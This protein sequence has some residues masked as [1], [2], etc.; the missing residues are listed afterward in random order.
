[1]KWKSSRTVAENARLLLPK[2]ADKYFKAGRKAAGEEAPSAKDLHRFRIAT[3]RFRYS[4]EL[5]R[6]VYGDTLE[7]HIRSLRELQNVLGALSDYHSLERLFQGDRELRA[8]LDRATSRKLREFR[9][10][11]RAFDSD[12]RRE[13][14]NQYLTRKTRR[15]A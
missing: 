12:D 8:K 9:A 2:L 10:A 13:R 14:W 3:K 11:W 1:M 15:R 4:L 5:F 6:P 7:T